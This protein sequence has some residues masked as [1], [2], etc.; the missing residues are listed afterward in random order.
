MPHLLLGLE[1]HASHPSGGVCS[2]GVWEGRDVAKMRRAR[3]K[4]QGSGQN[5]VEFVQNCVAL[6]NVVRNVCNSQHM[7]QKTPT[8]FASVHHHSTDH[9]NGRPCYFTACPL[10]CVAGG[11]RGCLDRQESPKGG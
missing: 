3:V 2:R 7:L 9:S 8:V 11:G 1:S 5:V 4:G 10:A 6:P